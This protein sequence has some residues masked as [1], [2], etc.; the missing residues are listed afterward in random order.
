M[1]SKSN[2]RA[3]MIIDEVDEFI[4]EFF[5]SLNNRNQNK[6]KSM[7]GSEFVFDFFLTHCIISVIK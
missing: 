2:K 7:T 5:D 3:I 4:K 6:L 1:H